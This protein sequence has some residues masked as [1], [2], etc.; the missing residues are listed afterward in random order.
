MSEARILA[1]FWKPKS[2][3]FCELTSDEIMERSGHHVT[4]GTFRALIEHRVVIY[5]TIVTCSRIKLYRLAPEGE[6]RVSAMIVMNRLPKFGRRL[7]AI[8]QEVK[9]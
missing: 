3:R 1:A 8:P 4:C 2:R 5:S 6:R 7:T 9:A